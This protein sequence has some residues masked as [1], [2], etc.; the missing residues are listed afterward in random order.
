M[1]TV[2][3]ENIGTLHD[4][5]TVKLT[6]EDY[7]PSFEKSL[8]QYAKTAN[9]PG[10]RK[11]NVPSGMVKKMYGQ[12]IFG[13]EVLRAAGSKLEEYLKNEQVSIFA[14]PMVMPNEKP[15]SLDMNA[16]IDVDFAFEVG[17]KPEFEIS[18]IKN[19]AALTK[20]KV[21]IAD[22][23]VDDETERITKRYGNAE[24]QPEVT[25]KDDI[26]YSKYEL[27]DA[28]GNVAAESKMVEDTVLLEKLPAKLQEMLM[29]KKNEESF[30]I[31]PADVC[32]AD[33]L[34]GFM[35]DPLK[36]GVEAANNY[37]KFTLTRV[38]KLQPRELNEEL[39]AQIFPNDEIK[40][41][42]AFKER[43]RAEL[44][45]EYDR[46]SRERL[47]NEIYEML[48]H[49]TSFELPVPFLKRWLK[50]GGEKPKSETEVENEFGAFDHQL[51]WTLI[52]DKLIIENGISVSIEEVK[53]HI[54]AQVLGYFGMGADG[55][56]PWLESYMQKVMKDEKTMDETYRRLL[57]EKLFTF[58]E[59]QFSIT[60]QEVSEEEFYKLPDAHAAHHHHH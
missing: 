31:R 26:I 49:N 53:E 21:A 27:C 39:F 29:G 38:A 14:Q 32:T 42:A 24:T 57:F 52:S 18:A 15:L 45:K 10:F 16:P 12:S 20:Y 4:K 54:K 17:V 33:E 1:A 6:K 9:I 40:D 41:V 25:S 48:V 34:A 28:E 30:V 35:K 55:D 2:T 22:K 36:E 50:E 19:K 5:I 60:E 43:L 46:V 7:M 13:D 56:A 8:K 44:S 3:R 23:M 11:G 59:T 51:R 37:Y 58:L 47:H